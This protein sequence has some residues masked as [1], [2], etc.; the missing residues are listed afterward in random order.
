M[1]EKLMP[2]NIEAEEAVLGSALIDP[3]L[4]Q[5]LRWLQPADFYRDAHRTIWQAMQTLARR[6]MP[7]DEI[8]LCDALQREGKLEDVGGWASIA[9]L[10][11]RVPTSAHAEYYAAI[12]A[13]MAIARRAIHAAG[14]IAA[15][16]YNDLNL[17][18]PEFR[19]K[20]LDLILKATQDHGR[21]R[22]EPLSD[23]LRALQEETYNRLE[24]DL[25][26]HLL[27]P[28]FP[29]RTGCWWASSGAI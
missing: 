15:L 6:R 12:I 22:A 10:I 18:T 26:A 28:G 13:R 2:Q 14:Q 3:E 29:E 21:S 8:T 24:G 17:D 5:M 16:A 19:R 1:M 4:M 20:C 25:E 23:V 7:P 27:L 11:N 9:S